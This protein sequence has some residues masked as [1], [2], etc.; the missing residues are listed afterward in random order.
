[1][2]SIGDVRKKKREKANMHMI[3]VQGNLSVR[4]SKVL[5]TTLTAAFLYFGSLATGQTT[6]SAPANLSANEWKQV[7]DAMGRPGQI[8]PGD[9]MRFGMPQLV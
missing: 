7:E 9:V 2:T 8:Q 1:M 3:V 5:L 6:N 4:V